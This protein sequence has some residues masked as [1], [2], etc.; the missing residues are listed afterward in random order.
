MCVC[1]RSVSV[2]S[3]SVGTRTEAVKPVRWDQHKRFRGREIKGYHEKK[4][5]AVC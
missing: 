3:V 1:G 5:L 2:G 4:S